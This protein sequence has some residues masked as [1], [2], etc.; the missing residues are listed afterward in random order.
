MGQHLLRLTAEDHG[1]QAATSVRGHYDQVTAL[2][3]RCLDYGIPG[4]M[5]GDLLGFRVNDASEVGRDQTAWRSSVQRLGYCQSDDPRLRELG[6][7]PSDSC[8]SRSNVCFG[9]KHAREGTKLRRSYCINSFFS[10]GPSPPHSP[11]CKQKSVVSP[12][13]GP[14]TYICKVPRRRPYQ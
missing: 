2:F 8:L 10:N 4:V 12:P 11:G 13:L 1:G 3:L 9:I 6:K 7:A 5:G 14:T